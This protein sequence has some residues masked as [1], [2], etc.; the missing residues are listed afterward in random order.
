LGSDANSREIS[1]TAAE[2]RT[3]RAPAEATAD[4]IGHKMVVMQPPVEHLP[5]AMIVD[6]VPAAVTSNPLACFGR[7]SRRSQY[8]SV[9]PRREHSEAAG[10]GAAQH[11][12]SSSTVCVRSSRRAST[13]GVCSA[14]ITSA[15]AEAAA[16]A[17]AKPPRPR[18]PLGDI[19]NAVPAPVA[20]HF[21]GLPSKRKSAVEASKSSTAQLSSQPSR[22]PMAVEFSTA[23]VLNTLDA[24]R[25]HPQPPMDYM[26]HQRVVHGGMRAVLVDWLIDVH[27]TYELRNETL[28]L[29][30]C[31]VDAYLAR[32]QASRRDLQLIGVAALFIA[33]K[34]EEIHP[35][36]VKEFVYVTARSYTKQ[37][38]F[39]MEL[40]I[41]A[42]LDFQVARPTVA[43]FLQR[44]EAETPTQLVTERD[45]VLAELPWYLAELCLLDVGMLHFTPSCIAVA[46][47]TLTRRLLGVSIAGSQPCMDLIIRRLQPAVL[48]ECEKF[49]LN[50]LEAAP[51]TATTAAVR[52]KHRCIEILNE[53]AMDEEQMPET[54]EEAV[55][56]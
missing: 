4:K 45:Q 55:A 33:A 39:D 6:S 9:H 29:A 32:V 21:H 41:L 25:R 54:M 42:R 10:A 2:T 28:F 52:R 15:D 23:L 27:A 7:S 49:L 1:A 30:V 11:R 38:I 8:E 35:P 40:R 20:Q 43:H 14:P 50:L 22:P 34:Y 51:T 36:E 3:S 26:E 44:L 46:T 12:G 5:E 47:L 17:H 37:E 18:A 24:E 53:G 13:T 31:I 48:E 19:T 16:A 56:I